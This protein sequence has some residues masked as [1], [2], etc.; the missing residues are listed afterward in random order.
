MST[1]ARGAGEAAYDPRVALEFFKAAGTPEKI[2]QGATIFAEQEKKGLFKRSKVYLLLAGQVDLVAGAKTIGAVKPGEIFGELAAIARTPRSASA[3]AASECK[4]I[5][6]DGK[7]LEAA[8]RKKPAFALMLM[9]VMIRRLRETVRALEASGALAP[10]SAAN[11]GAAFDPKHLAELLR[12]LSD[13]PPVH[14]N[15]GLPIMLA[16]QAGL[17][18]YVVTEGRVAVTI[19]EQVVERLGPG[20]A[21]GEA[22]LLEQSTRLASAAAETDCSLLPISRAAFL[23][24]VKMSPGFAESML[25]SLAGRLRFLTSRLK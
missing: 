16:G 15:R 3:V 9:S 23:A 22:A 13:D 4:V 12:G 19:G 8:L 25:G 6:L 11:E 10:D 5:A 21:F 7:E 18:M 20:G 14:F 17:R 24:L 1:V 2:A